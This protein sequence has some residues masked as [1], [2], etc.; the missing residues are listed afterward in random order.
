MIKIIGDVHGKTGD[1]KRL[2]RNMPPGQRSIQVGDMGLGFHGVRLHDMSSDH[3]FFRG[4]HDNPAKCKAN[5]YYLGDCGFMPE[6]NLFWIAGAFSID[7]DFRQPMTEWWPDEELSFEEL[8][9]AIDLYVASKPKY[10]LSHEAPS[11]VGRYLLSKLIGPHYAS[12]EDCCNSRTSQALQVMFY[13][14]KPKE[15]VF[16]HYHVSETFE[17]DGTKFTCVP[18]LGVYDLHIEQ[19]ES[20]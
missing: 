20:L 8:Y 9:H 16:G 12:K 6:D 14:H 2:I 4:N 3:K 13:L 10:V 18:E 1:Y 15:W 7:R 17:L 5:K 19:Q 11:R